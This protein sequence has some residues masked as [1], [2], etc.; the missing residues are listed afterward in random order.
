MTVQERQP[1]H[2]GHIQRQEQILSQAI[3]LLGP[4]IIGAQAK[5]VVESGYSARHAGLMDYHVVFAQLNRVAPVP[6]IVQDAN[7]TDAARVRTD[8]LR[9]HDETHSATPRGTQP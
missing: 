7:E 1:A 9:W 3:D 8:L 5:D 6:L 4:R 2:P